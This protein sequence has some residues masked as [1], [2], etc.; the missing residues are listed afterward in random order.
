[1]NRRNFLA[2]SVAATFAPKALIAEDLSEASI[3]TAC[4]Q[5]S[6]YLANS[7]M[8]TKEAIA[9]GVYESAFY[10][11]SMAVILGP[12]LQTQ[13][14]RV[15]RDTPEWNRYFKDSCTWHLKSEDSTD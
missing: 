7:M 2:A 1:M 8:A 12:G 14:N 3:E 5:L 9:A 11:T 10:G 15:Y 6:Q 13:I 4:E